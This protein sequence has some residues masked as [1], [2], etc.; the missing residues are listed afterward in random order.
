MELENAR[1]EINDI[2]K[3]IVKLLEKRFT[4]VLQ[5]GRYKKKNSVPVYDE[6]REKAVIEN[7]VNNLE[8][9]TYSRE[10]EMIFKQIMDSC[11]EL[12]K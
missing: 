10:V 3:E 9:K 6:K 5:V 12:E 7:C 4:L 11:K 2:D 1:N 8:N